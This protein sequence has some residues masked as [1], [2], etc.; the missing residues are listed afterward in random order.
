MAKF[1]IAKFVV[2]RC[3]FENFEWVVLFRQ[4]FDWGWS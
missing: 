4:S 1:V 3:V 2:S